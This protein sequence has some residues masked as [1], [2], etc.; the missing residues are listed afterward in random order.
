MREGRD[1]R[2]R[3][4]DQRFVNPQ[5]QQQ[6]QQQI[7]RRYTGIPTPTAPQLKI[8]QG[9]S[10]FRATQPQARRGEGKAD[11]IDERSALVRGKLDSVK[12]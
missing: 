6:Q 3:T 4:R 1:R 9:G 2:Q 5:E 7:E 10:V 8:G 12:R 11:K